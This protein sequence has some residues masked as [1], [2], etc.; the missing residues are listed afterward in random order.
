M[1]KMKNQRKQKPEKGGGSF[2]IN[3]NVEIQKT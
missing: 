2:L 1:R 3:T